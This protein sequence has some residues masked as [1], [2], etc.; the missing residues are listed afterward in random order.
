MTLSEYASK[1]FGGTIRDSRTF[2]LK[3]QSAIAQLS[4]NDPDGRVSLAML[5]DLRLG[6]CR[7][8]S[9][10]YKYLC[11]HMHRFPEQWGLTA[12]SQSDGSGPGVVR[13][14]I[15]CQLVRG[16]QS[17]VAADGSDV[18]Q[19]HMWNVVRLGSELFVVDVMQRPG[20][21]L[22]ADSKEAQAYQR[23]I[24]AS[25]EPSEV[26]PQV[27]E[28]HPLCEAMTSET[29]GREQR[30]GIIPFLCVQPSFASLI[31]FDFA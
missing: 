22:P 28:V 31:A 14:A 15:P 1:E 16:V 5:I 2:E 20:Q 3:V 8:R 6:V 21:L 9:I 19:N 10:L 30:P 7:H 17:E 13:G 27:R 29:L 18:A 11:D 12:A 24:Q 4:S 26:Q 25:A 23:A